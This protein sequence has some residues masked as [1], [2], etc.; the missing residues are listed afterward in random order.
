MKITFNISFYIFVSILILSGYINYL[1]SYLIIMFIHELGHITIIKL[2]KYKITSIYIIPG[3]G[4]I[5]TNINL[6]IKSFHLFLISI[7][8]IL[9][10]I[11]LLLINNN[12]C[13]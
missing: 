2:L 3:G 13:S 7:S 1:V 9:F 8:G 6:N 12:I 4:I 5:N 10:Q 11:P